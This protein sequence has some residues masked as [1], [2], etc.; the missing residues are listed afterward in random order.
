MDWRK[1]LTVARHEYATNIRRPGFII[2]TALVPALAILGLLIASLGGGLFG[3]QIANRMG[4]F[5]ENYFEGSSKR[6]GV[7]DYS[8]Y[9]KSIRPEFRDNFV[10]YPTEE[11]AKQALTDGKLDAV[12]VIPENYLETGKVTVLTKG[13]GFATT[14]YEDS[15]LVKSFFVTHLLGEDV[16]PTLRKRISDPFNSVPMVISPQ[17]EVRGGGPLGVVFTFII[18][19]FLAF[20][21]IMT[22]FVSSGYLLQS[23]AEEK[24]NRIVEIIIS[25]ITPMELMAG[26]VIGLGSLGLTQILVW[27]LTLVGFSSGAV[28]IFAVAGAFALPLRTLVLVVVYYLLGFALYAVLMAGIG[29][30]GTTMR[31]SQQLAGI[32]S[33]FAAIPYMLSGFLFANP[34]ALLARILSYFPL[35]A[36]T[37]MMMRLPLGEVPWV[38]VIVSVVVLVLSIPVALWFGGKLFRIGLLIYGKRPSLKEIILILRSP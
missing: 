8:G 38:D 21:L 18:P 24:E 10:P 30:L 35:T 15:S 33:M 23:V 4:R 2:M 25:S 32:F 36:P 11:E 26:K 19:Y 17:G 29:A 22:I 13:S 34:N 28:L 3:S 14:V 7:V 5:F 31:E 9:F 16:D 1:V 20:F 6:I 27:L 37:M 12:F